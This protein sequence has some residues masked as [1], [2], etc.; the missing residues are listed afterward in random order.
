MCASEFNYRRD[1]SGNC[2]LVDGATPLSSNT[3]EEQCDGYTEFWY[4]R[5]E[6]RKIPYSSCEGG[7][8]PDLGKRHQCPGLIIGGVRRGA[9]FWGSIAILPFAFAG[10]A[11]YWWLKKGDRAGSIRLGDHRAFGGDSTSG[12]LA[13]IA[14]VPMFLI[15]IGQEGWAW[16]TRRVPFVEDLFTRRSSSYRSVPVDE[17]GECFVQPPSLWQN[18]TDPC[19]AEIL[20]NYED[21]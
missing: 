1:S 21:E 18:S 3:E 7:E 20:G 14:S 9:L 13:V 12:V 15:A 11:G 6:Y 5:T 2:V 10:L 17:D 8:R 4:E 19:L 16:V